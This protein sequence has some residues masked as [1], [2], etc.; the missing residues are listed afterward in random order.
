VRH[1]GLYGIGT[2]LLVAVPAF[3]LVVGCAQPAAT[4]TTPTLHNEPAVQL[5]YFSTLIE[6]FAEAET[7]QVITESR[8]DATTVLKSH[9]ALERPRRFHVTHDADGTQSHLI[10]DGNRTWVLFGSA[11]ECVTWPGDL[12]ADFEP[13]L[14]VDLFFRARDIADGKDPYGQALA[15]AE[16]VRVDEVDGVRCDVVEIPEEHNSVA[17]VFWMAQSTHLPIRVGIMRPG[18]TTDFALTQ[19]ATNVALDDAL[20]SFA[21]TPE[22]TVQGGTEADGVGGPATRPA[23]TPPVSIPPEDLERLRALGYISAETQPAAPPPSD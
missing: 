11:N 8:F 3:F 18:G 5:G 21:P 22:W 10:S 23:V 14:F 15:A 17:R 2:C 6:R 20:F 13:W 12:C 19:F 4:R 7:L 9:V 1:A 16:L